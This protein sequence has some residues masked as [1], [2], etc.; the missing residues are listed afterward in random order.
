MKRRR[1][2][3]VAA[4]L[5]VAACKSPGQG[6]SHVCGP[7]SAVVTATATPTELKVNWDLGVPIVEVFIDGHGPLNF[8]LDSGA[9]VYAVDRRVAKVCADVLSVVPDRQVIDTVSALLRF[10]GGVAGTFTAFQ[11]AAGSE[12]DIRLRIY[13]ESGMI[14]WSHRE[15]SYLRVAMLNQG[16]RV[17]GRG[18]ADLPPE[19]VALG[20]IPRGHPEGLREAFANIY[21]EVAQ[22]RMLRSLG[23]AAPSFRYPRIEDGAHTMAFIEACI[24]SNGRWV[25][26]T[27]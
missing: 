22:E 16:A 27:G 20:R 14:E 11:A 19:I 10:E 1:V 12:N 7:T 13:G 26:V 3:L 17:I 9:A 5:L 4:A 8:V 6:S 2:V 21:G 25:D 23:E 18:D 24:A 15:A